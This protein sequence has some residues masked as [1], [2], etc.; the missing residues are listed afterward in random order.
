MFHVNMLHIQ[1]ETFALRTRKMCVLGV[2]RKNNFVYKDKQTSYTN[3]N[4]FV[5]EENQFRI[6]RNVSLYTKRNAIIYE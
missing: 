4:S 5:Y 3:N 6:R 2:R 1:Y